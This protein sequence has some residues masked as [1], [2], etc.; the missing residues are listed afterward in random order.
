[1]PHLDYDTQRFGPDGCAWPKLVGELDTACAPLLDAARQVGAQV[2]VVNEYA[3]V[4][5]NQSVPLNRVLGEELVVT[6]RGPF[7]TQL[8]TFASRAFAVCDHQV[9]HIYVNEPGLAES[10]RS[11]QH[12]GIERV[13]VGAE[14][15]EIGLDHPRAGDAVALAKPHAWF[16]YPFWD[17]ASVPPDYARTV[18][19]HRKPGYDPCELL[20][21]PRLRVPKLRVVRRLLAKKLGFRTLFDVIATDPQ[22]VRGSHGL[23]MA[24]PVDKPLLIGTGPAPGAAVV[25]QLGVRDLILQTL[26]AGAR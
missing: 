25:Q 22:L 23:P 1:L 11:W 7:G 26:V 2:W 8:D 18:D 19:I 17:E 20:F 13:Y 3:H 15:R 21:D 9:A 12:P 24:D 10:L 5:V 6:R 16:A 14:R 4:Q